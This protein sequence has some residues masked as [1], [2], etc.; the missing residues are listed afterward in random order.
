MIKLNKYITGLEE[1]VEKIEEQIERL[2][3]KEMPSKKRQTS[4]TE[5]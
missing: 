4:M 2:E 3:E 5:K 1:V